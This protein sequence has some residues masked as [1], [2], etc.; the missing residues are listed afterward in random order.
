LER[1]SKKSPFPDL[2]LLIGSNYS[3]SRSAQV[4][5]V[6]ISRTE[7]YGLLQ[8]AILTRQSNFSKSQNQFYEQKAEMVQELAGVII[9]RRAAKRGTIANHIH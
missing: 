3:I 7:L 4:Q 5:P 8:A 6:R 9:D 1:R 2:Q